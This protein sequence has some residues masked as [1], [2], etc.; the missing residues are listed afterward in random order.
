LDQRLVSVANTKTH[1]TPDYIPSYFY[2][3]KE[4]DNLPSTD[5]SLGIS[6]RTC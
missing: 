3:R 2:D 6:R 4:A 5:S 1:F